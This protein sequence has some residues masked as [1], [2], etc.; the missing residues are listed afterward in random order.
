MK[1]LELKHIAPYLNYELKCQTVDEGEAVISEL[2]AAYSDNSYSFMNIV[3]SEKGFEEIKPILRPLSDLTKE[4]EVNGEKFVP[5]VEIGKI[6]GFG[7]L[8]RFE[9]EDGIVEYGWNSHG[10]E[11]TQPYAFGYFEDGKFGVWYDCVDDSYPIDEHCSM[12]STSKLL[13]WH[14]DVFGLIEQGLAIDIN[15]LEI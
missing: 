13:E 5:I 2:N 10:M 15:T 12:S 7:F 9:E 14:F 4:I 6:L 11:D 3:E 8:Q 1:K